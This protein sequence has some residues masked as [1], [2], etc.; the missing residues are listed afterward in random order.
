MFSK[1]PMSKKYK[2]G[3]FL[4]CLFYILYIDMENERLRKLLEKTRNS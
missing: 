4:I 2:K 3:R 1:N